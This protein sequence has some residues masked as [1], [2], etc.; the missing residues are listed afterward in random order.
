VQWI[1]GSIKTTADEAVV[2]QGGNRHDEETALEAEDF[3]RS[4]LGAGPVESKKIQV[5]AREAGLGRRALDR[6]KAS[7]KVKAQKTSSGWV[8]AINGTACTP[9]WATR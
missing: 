9:E 8:W 5:E 1:E 7:L 4:M 2:A 3:L 6:A